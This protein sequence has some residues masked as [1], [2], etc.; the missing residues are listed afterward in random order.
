MARHLADADHAR[1]DAFVRRLWDAV[2]DPDNAGA[3][4][5]LPRSDAFCVWDPV[6]FSASVLPDLGVPN[7]STFLRRLREYGFRPLP[8]ARNQFEH[9]HFRRNAAHLLHSLRR[10]PA[11]CVSSSSSE[12]ESDDGGCDDGAGQGNTSQGPLGECPVDVETLRALV[13]ELAQLQLEADKSRAM[14]AAVQSELEASERRQKALEVTA[15]MLSA[16][17]READTSPGALRDAGRSS[18]DVASATSSSSR[19]AGGGSSLVGALL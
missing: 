11:A 18:D 4:G 16:Q 1:V 2:G 6:E 5:W 19:V 14:V 17:Q 12:D 7:Y 3:V 13:A 10:R 15:E 9:K 8:R